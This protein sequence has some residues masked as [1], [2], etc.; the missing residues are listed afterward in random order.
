[1]SDFPWRVRNY[2]RRFVDEGRVTTLIWFL[3][4]S[5]AIAGIEWTLSPANAHFFWLPNSL[6]FSAYLIVLSVFASAWLAVVIGGFIK[7]G[8][9][10]LLMLIPIKWGLFPVYLIF[11]I[12]WSCVV[13]GA[14]I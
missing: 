8:W 1:M 10:G 5:Y 4:A 14:C 6:S 2:L 13:H 7:C 3:L 9:A 12:Y 11:M